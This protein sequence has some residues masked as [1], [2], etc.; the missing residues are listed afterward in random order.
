MNKEFWKD[1]NV[2]VTGAMGFLPSWI[3]I[4][5]AKN[6]ANVIGLTNDWFPQS[7]LKLSG[8]DKKVTMVQANITDFTD[9]K[10]IFNEYEIQFCFHL[11]A[12]TTVPVSNR[13][14]MSTFEINAKGT[15]T[16]IEAARQT[17]TFEGFL[18]ASSDK[19]YGDQPVLPYTETQPLL[20]RYPYDVSKMCAEMALQ[21]YFHT[22]KVPVAIT[23]C[24]NIYGGGDLHW[25]R[26]VPS[27]I[28]SVLRNEAPVLRSDGTPLRDFIYVLDAVNAYLTL[29]ENISR[30]DVKGQA[31]NFTGKTPTRIIDLVT[32]IIGAMGK[33]NLKPKIMGSGKPV[34]EIDEQYLS[35]EKAQRILNWKPE[36]S[37]KEGMKL[38][39]DWYKDYFKKNGGVSAARSP[40][41]VK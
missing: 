5:L 21:S 25:S 13:D 1:K 4:E 7:W 37:L 6:G 2:I 39:V 19:V 41:A 38:T 16:L 29:A 32:T 26:I 30:D 17:P 31:F 15:W 28:R 12:I 34:G 8:W 3:C 36:Y 14:P 40:L 20:A 9:M 35:S 22:Y 24:A 33:K 18:F 23:R 27:T 10:R 11:A